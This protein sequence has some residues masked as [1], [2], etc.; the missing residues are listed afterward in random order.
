MSLNRVELI[1]NLGGEPKFKEFDNGGAVCNVTLATTDRGFTT[2]D[3]R[4]IEEHTE[5]HNVV[6][7]NGLAKV[8]GKYA[9]KGDKVFVSG[10]LRTR[11]YE[12]DGQTKY[13]TE[14]IAD[15]F[16]FMQGRQQSQQ[17]VQNAV[18]NFINALDEYAEPF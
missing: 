6:F 10:K 16:E 7:R 8:L 13:M 1:G 5:W 9:H 15:S 11:Q 14:I 17:N 3:G 2:K 12:Q 18:D 4:K